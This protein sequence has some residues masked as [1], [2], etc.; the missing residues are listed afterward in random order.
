MA[1]F[2]GSPLFFIIGIVVILALGGF[3]IM[4][5]NKKDE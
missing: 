2:I 5:R 1:D 3:L 4:M